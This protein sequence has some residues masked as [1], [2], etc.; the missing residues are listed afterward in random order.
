MENITVSSRLSLF[1]NYANNPQNIDVNWETLIE[2]KVNRFISATI[3]THLIYDD[4]I[5][6]QDRDGNTGPRTQF[7]EVI[8]VGFSY[9][10]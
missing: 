9:K 7:K 6:I 5:A 10:F 8:G 3:A 1:S 2:L 4:D